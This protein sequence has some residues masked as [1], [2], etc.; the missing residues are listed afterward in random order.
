[1]QK[2][3]RTFASITFQNYFRLYN[4]LS[5]MTGTAETSSEEFYKVYGLQTIVI[6]SNKPSKRLDLDDYIFQTENG[7]FKAIA[8]KVKELSDLGQ[9]VLIGT[10]SI[11]KNELLSKYLLQQGVKHEILNAKNHEREGEIVAQAGRRGAVTI[12]TN[13]AGRGVDIK[14][15]GNPGSAEAYEEVKTIGGLFVLGTER[16]E[17]PR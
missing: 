7:K 3:S 17:A 8:R 9:P 4:K 6:P 13:M 16:H 15:G 10:V 1:M 11:E 2:E 14:L 5:G 12:A